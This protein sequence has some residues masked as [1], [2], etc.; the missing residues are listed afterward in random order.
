M[1]RNLIYKIGNVPEVSVTEEKI[2]RASREYNCCGLGLGCL[3]V[4]NARQMLQGYLSPAVGQHSKSCLIQIDLVPS[5]STS[6]HCYSHREWDGTKARYRRAEGSGTGSKGEANPFVSRLWSW[7]WLNKSGRNFQDSM[8]ASGRITSQKIFTIGGAIWSTN[9]N[10]LRSKR[11]Q[12]LGHKT[13]TTISNT[14]IYHYNFWGQRVGESLPPFS[15]S[16]IWG[17]RLGQKPVLPSVMEPYI[18]IIFGGRG[19][20]RGGISKKGEMGAEA[21]I[22]FYHQWS[23]ASVGLPYTYYVMQDRFAILRPCKQ[24]TNEQWPIYNSRTT[25]ASCS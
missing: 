24:K 12:R 19:W 1:G 13:S 11:G 6:C 16:I 15:C 20:G 21:W 3:D 10:S 17:Q 5:S 8:R 25:W 18:I 14:A 9:A 23:L 2:P 4:S 7:T 22:Y